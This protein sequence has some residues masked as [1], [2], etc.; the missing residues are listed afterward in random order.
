[1]AGA[2]ALAISSRPAAVARPRNLS[3]D[4]A[5]GFGILLVVLGH[6]SVFR[7]SLHTAYEAVYLF[8]MP[9][10]FFLSGTTF[11]QTS[12]REVMRKRARSLL[13]PYFAMGMLAVA[14][15]VLEGGPDRVA[16]N[17]AGILYGTGHTLR[18]TPLWF[19]PCLFLVV[20]TAAAL[21]AVRGGPATGEGADA[22]LRRFLSFAA[23]T[24]LAVG[25][26]IL[27]SGR[28]A[29]PPFT[30]AYSRP[31][32]LPWSLDLVPFALG[33]FLLGFLLARARI[34]WSPRR[35][36]L[37]VASASLI[38][39]LLAASGVSLDLNYRRMTDPLAAILGAASGIVLV[40]T[41]SALVARRPALA[42][43]FAYLGSASL[44]LL[45]F[46]GPVQ[47]RVVEHLAAGLEQ[48]L[49]VVVLGTGLSV[50]IVCL[51]DVC[52]LRR[53]PAFGW[54]CYPRRSVRS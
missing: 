6:N 12:F 36:V 25:T 46:H 28:F 35:P 52:I 14:L 41:L 48:P 18:F 10:F 54:I 42:R 45:L 2:D 44:A 34:L 49:V 27:M 11:R 5:K 43:V 50:A 31:L 21:L 1:M 20:T 19:L 4:V 17:V 8:H 40:I 39:A 47:R 51:A 7:T 16:P 37:L 13:V 30:D 22:Q 15:G 32:G 33:T 26:G 38:L 29:S 3:I 53:M 24:S 9:L 23:V